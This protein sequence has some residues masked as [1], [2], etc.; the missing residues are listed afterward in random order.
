MNPADRFKA[1]G[2]D[3]SWTGAIPMK[4]AR[5]TRMPVRVSAHCPRALHFVLAGKANE[6]LDC[7]VTLTPEVVNKSRTFSCHLDNIF[8]KYTFKR[9][10]MIG[11]IFLWIF[12]SKLYKSFVCKRL[13]EDENLIMNFRPPSYVMQY[14]FIMATR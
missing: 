14:V 12:V 7:S 9:R 3:E 6:K 2:S 5:R 13:E 1:C 11:L 4:D 8:V 10:I